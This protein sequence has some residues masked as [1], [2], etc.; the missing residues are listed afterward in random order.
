MKSQS[1]RPV[2]CASG[3]TL[4]ELLIVIVIIAVL[5][6]IS[7]PVVSGLRNSANQ[8]A[9]ASNLRQISSAVLAYA[10]ENNGSLPSRISP[11]SGRS[12]GVSYILPDP[13]APQKSES[14]KG[15]S[16]G[17]KDYY[18]P[19]LL[20]SYTGD[21]DIWQCPGNKVGWEVTN[22][23][24]TYIINNQGFTKPPRLFGRLIGNGIEIG[25]P[26]TNPKK[27]ASLPD[28]ARTWMVATADRYNYPLDAYVTNDIQP[29]YKGK[30]HYVFF[31]GHIE[32]RDL[33]NLPEYGNMGWAIPK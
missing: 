4:T 31:D 18:M 10:A 29:A 8:S 19:Y 24:I 22:G 12:M 9:C 1:N 3:F 6:A 15:H 7:I 30:R 14:K 17:Q 27:L 20:Q 32:L 25:D 33:K 21:A 13:L 23:A 26:V 28:L 5:S 2:Y 11:V 16:D